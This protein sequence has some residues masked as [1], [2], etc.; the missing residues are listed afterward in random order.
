MKHSL[1]RDSKISRALASIA[2][3]SQRELILHFNKSSME[4]LHWNMNVHSAE[5]LLSF[6][7]KRRAE[8]ELEND[9]RLAKRFD[10]L[11]IGIHLFWTVYPA[12]ILI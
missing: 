10:L 1:K 11:N 8:D 4:G 12:T 9:Q 3:D 6:G 5:P 7:R 2:R